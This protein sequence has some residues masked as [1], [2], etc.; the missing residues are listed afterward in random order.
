MAHPDWSLYRAFA[1]VLRH[2]SLTAAAREIGVS[3]PTLGRRISA[4]EGHLG[5]ALFSRSPEGLAPT[6]EAD[7]LRPQ[8]AS[9]EAAASAL[10]DAAIGASSI[11][12]SLVR[13]S[14]SEIIAAE[15]LPCALRRLRRSNPDIELTVSVSN[16]VEDVL[17]RDADIAVRMTRPH[18]SD[19]LGRKVGEVELGLFAHPSCF[20]ERPPPT[21]PGELCQHPLVGFETARPY[22]QIL[23]L[24]G[25]PLRPDLFAYRTDS[26]TAQIGAIR[27]GLGIGVCHVPLSAGLQ[28]VLATQFCPRVEMWLVINR[29]LM[30][31]RRF[32]Q[33]FRTLWKELGAYV[34]P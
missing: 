22:T 32:R 26:D 28:R 31:T 11:G 29:D 17:R 20:A 30:R 13:V 9:L 3:Q 7:A 24:K 15:V 23:Q 21:E 5:Y 19:L 2:G 6:P 1:A 18:Q 8:L 4:L 33:V 16:S 10:S 14:A 12:R 27:A 25:Q 34:S